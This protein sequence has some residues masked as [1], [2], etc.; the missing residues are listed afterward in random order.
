M[1]NKTVWIVGGLVVAVGAVAFLS[2]HDTPAGKDAAG[3]IV[4]AK[5]AYADGTSGS[6]TGSQT[7][8]SNIGSDTSGAGG[9]SDRSGGNGTGADRGSGQNVGADRGSG[10][11]VGADRGSG[12][13]VGA[14]LRE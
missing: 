3:T 1:S 2:Y 13:N 12:Q 7:G 9:T 5:R 6:G 8:T 4:A 11:N 14:D 10:Q